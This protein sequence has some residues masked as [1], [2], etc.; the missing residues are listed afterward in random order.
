MNISGGVVDITTPH[1]YFWFSFPFR[2]SVGFHFLDPLNLGK[3]T[4]TCLGK[5]M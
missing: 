2:H 5:K 1:Q 3:A 4:T